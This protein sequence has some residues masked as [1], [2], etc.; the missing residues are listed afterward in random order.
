MSVLDE[1]ADAIGIEE[2]E[3]LDALRDGQTIAEVAESNGVDPQ[4]VI[5]ALVAATQERLD[6]AVADGRIEQEDA[7]ERLA[8]V[9]ERIT[10]FVNEGA[11]LRRAVPAARS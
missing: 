11:D 4:T 7:D 9:T 8:D 2:D 10:E 6:D 1:A 3:L 5:D